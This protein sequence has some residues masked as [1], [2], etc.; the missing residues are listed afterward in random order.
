VEHFVAAA[1][2]SNEWARGYNERYG[3]NVAITD[4]DAVRANW[5]AVVV[6]IEE[7]GY[8][9]GH[10]DGWYVGYEAGGEL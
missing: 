6:A 7:Q 8:E 2:R 4:I 10:D 3:A 1:T 9:D 5:T